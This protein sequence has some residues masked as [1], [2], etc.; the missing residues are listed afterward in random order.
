MFW[1]WPVHA[2]VFTTCVRNR[3]V[4]FIL[5]DNVTYLLDD[6]SDLFADSR[7]RDWINTVTGEVVS[8][9]RARK[10]SRVLSDAIA[11]DTVRTAYED[12]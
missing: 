8:T 1:R 5:A 9:R 3:T 10:L 4:Y 6:Y 12:T 2:L 7:Y 11:T